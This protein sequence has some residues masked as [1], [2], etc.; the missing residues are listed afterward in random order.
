MKKFSEDP[1]LFFSDSRKV[2][3]F[4]SK[5]LITRPIAQTTLSQSMCTAL[6]EHLIS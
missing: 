4:I 6:D 3:I 5:N 1:E 2:V